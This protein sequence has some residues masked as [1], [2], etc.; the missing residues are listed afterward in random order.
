MLT[1]NVYRT[2]E[3]QPCKISGSKLEVSQLD[4][5][6][7][8]YSGVIKLVEPNIRLIYI[9]RDKLCVH[10]LKIIFSLCAS[11]HSLIITIV[12]CNNLFGGFHII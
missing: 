10:I 11:V 9:H 6:T 4:P 2:L 7:I 3:V 12:L 8:T 1:S 5:K